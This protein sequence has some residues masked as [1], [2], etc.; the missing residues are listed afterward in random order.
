MSEL[1]LN[2]KLQRLITLFCNAYTLLR[3]E[4]G[5]SSDELMEEL[6]TDED[7]MMSYFSL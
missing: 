5:Y 4:H 3:C 6:G 2:E 7:E 1:E